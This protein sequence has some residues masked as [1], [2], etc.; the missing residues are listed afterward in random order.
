MANNQNKQRDPQ[1]SLAQ[2]MRYKKQRLN[3]QKRRNL[4]PGRPTLRQKLPT[5]KKQQSHSKLH[6]LVVLIIFSV[7]SLVALYF[8]SNLSL[9]DTITV[10]GT[11]VIPE[12]KIIDASQLNGNS[13]V[14]KTQLQSQKMIQKIKKK[15]PKIKSVKFSISRFNQINLKVDEY[16]TV[17]YLLNKNK[18]QAILENTQVLSN[19]LTQSDDAGPVFT[20][21]KQDQYLTT[22]IKAYMKFD[23]SVQS[24][25][26]EIKY[27]QKKH[28]PNRIYLYMNDGNKIVA[29]MQTI[30]QKIKYYATLA[31]QMKE[32]GIIDLEVG[33]FSKPYASQ[34]NKG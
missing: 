30:D 6:L 16:R 28:N 32:K 18:Y 22:T 14:F 20:H 8:A 23:K 21:F 2:W 31:K 25:I 15:Q 17:G 33:A 29:D 3:A 4:K 1:K 5:F 12:Q 13:N 7:T 34:E 24:A 11:Q 27:A 19:Q 10:T 9:V 26:S